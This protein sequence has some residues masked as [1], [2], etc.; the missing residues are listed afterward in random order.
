ME[1]AM[2]YI[3]LLFIGIILVTYTIILS[4][5]AAAPPKPDF[6]VLTQPVPCQPQYNNCDE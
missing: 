4:G 6:S 3:Y 2:K 5:C 1:N